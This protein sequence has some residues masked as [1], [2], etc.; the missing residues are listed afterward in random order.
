MK[1]QYIFT[2]ERLGFRNWSPADYPRM[3][4]IS[5]DPHVMEF[6]PA[7]ATPAQTAEFINRMKK[8]YAQKGY[9]YFATDELKTG[10]FIGFIGLCHQTYASEFTPC[11]DIGWRLRKA[12]WG[13]GYATE[14][15]KRCLAYAFND[16]KLKN[17]KATAP[18]IN[19][20][21]IRVMEKIGMRK[22]LE[23]THPRLRG[24]KTLGNSVCYEID[25]VDI[26]D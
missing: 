15:A 4:E 6:F 24:H 12:Y 19:L 2:S 10:N 11:V 16:L 3:T 9:C 7:P 1:H 20:K 13:K 26:Q 25:N 23:F 14:G 17:I 22:Q 18:Q 8:M 5:S 21:S